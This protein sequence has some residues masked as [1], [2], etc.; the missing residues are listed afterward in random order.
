MEEIWSVLA[1]AAIA[2]LKVLA[3]FA[4]AVAFSLN[5]IELFVALFGG[6]MIGVL[7]FAFFG[8]RI[9]RYFAMKNRAK[10]KKINFKRIRTILKIW[11]R[12]GLVGI[13]VLTPPFLTP[14][15]GTLL[16]VAFGERFNRIVIAM[17]ISF[18]FWCSA[19]ALF[20]DQISKWIHEIF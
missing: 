9:R 5:K 1:V 12:F 17:G 15:I 19:L 6:G 7:F 2:S 8:T 13:A 16:A 14:P 20:G 3:A 4:V 10:N 18:A 11:R